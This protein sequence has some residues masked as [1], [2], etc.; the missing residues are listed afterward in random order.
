MTD[1]MLAVVALSVL[2]VLSSTY[3]WASL[4]I[5]GIFNLCGFL[6]ILIWLE[7]KAR[8]FR[9]TSGLQTGA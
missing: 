6:A 4:L 9:I 1:V 7:G 3:L 2:F 5:V 8:P